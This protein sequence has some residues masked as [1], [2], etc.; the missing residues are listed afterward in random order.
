MSINAPVTEILDSSRFLSFGFSIAASLI[1]V[2]T[3]LF[4]TI[5]F[6]KNDHSCIIPSILSLEGAVASLWT[7]MDCLLLLPR[8]KLLASLSQ[9][10]DGFSWFSS[11]LSFI[12][13]HLY[14]TP[15]THKFILGFLCHLIG[16]H[17][18]M[19][20]PFFQRQIIDLDSAILCIAEAD[21]NLWSSRS[22]CCFH[23][24]LFWEA[25]PLC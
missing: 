19:S 13:T 15:K 14:P 1:A 8:S 24:S 16:I 4:Q 2:R 5:V 17:I 6:C 21:R 22:V 9:F 25:P 10:I 20:N 11:I 23:L 12:V 3:T 18:S 7:L